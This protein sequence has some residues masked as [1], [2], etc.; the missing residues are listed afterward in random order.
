MPI[1]KA[2]FGKTLKLTSTRLQ[3]TD[4]LGAYAITLKEFRRA[5]RTDDASCVIHQLEPNGR[6]TDITLRVTF[7]KPTAYSDGRIGCCTLPRQEFFRISR[8][9]FGRKT[10]KKARAAKAGA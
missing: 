3:E 7:R 1:I 6:M 8:M 2:H 10:T 5:H 4:L 9:A